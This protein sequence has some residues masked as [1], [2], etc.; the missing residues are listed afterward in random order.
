MIVSCTVVIVVAG[1]CCSPGRQ[2]SSAA[3]SDNR[4][5]PYSILKRILSGRTKSPHTAT[6]ITAFNDTSFELDENL[7]DSGL[8]VF[9][10]IVERNDLLGVLASLLPPLPG[11]ATNSPYDFIDR[12]SIELSSFQLADFEPSS[13]KTTPIEKMLVDS[14]I[15]RTYHFIEP[16]PVHDRL[17]ISIRSIIQQCQIFQFA[18]AIQ[19]VYEASESRLSIYVIS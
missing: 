15:S 2:A 3:S 14:I 4:L 9:R 17:R 7:S 16:S 1:H 6:V 8:Q 19:S 13:I 18:V 5:F 11:V 12:S 10:S